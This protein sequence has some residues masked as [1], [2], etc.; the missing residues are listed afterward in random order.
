MRVE[1]AQKMEKTGTLEKPGESVRFQLITG[2]GNEVYVAGTF[3]N[4]DSHAHPLTFAPE[5]GSYLATLIIPP[6]RHEYK[7][8]VNG[9]WLADPKCPETVQNPLGSVNCVIVV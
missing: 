9:K 6:G 1:K 8:V 7:F 5:A 2:L 4:W 3:N